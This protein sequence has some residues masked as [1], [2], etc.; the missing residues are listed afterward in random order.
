M[1]NVYICGIRKEN[2]KKRLRNSSQFCWLSEFLEKSRN[3][4]IAHLRGRL[5][6]DHDVI[7]MKSS[8]NFAELSGNILE[9]KK[10]TRFYYHT[11][12]LIQ[13]WRVG[14]LFICFDSLTPIPHRPKPSLRD[15][16]SYKDRRCIWQPTEWYGKNLSEHPWMGTIEWLW[17]KLNVH[18]RNYRP[19][20]FCS[21]IEGKRFVKTF[22]LP[23][24]LGGNFSSTKEEY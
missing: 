3:P 8:P 22:H 24:R 17:L 14:S 6:G 16:L 12:I 11:L 5:R 23:S 21:K 18:R 1:S 19:S 9:G 15:Q 10:Y 4:L 7:P 2:L 13:S 20:S